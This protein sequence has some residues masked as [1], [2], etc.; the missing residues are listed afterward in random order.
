MWLSS[1][2]TGVLVIYG[3]VRFTRVFFELGELHFLKL[4]PSFN[5]F[6]G[7]SLL[8]L[9]YYLSLVGASCTHGCSFPYY[10]KAECSL[11]V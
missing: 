4:W 10:C 8:I 2:F 9:D 1:K 3:I 11:H 7:I 5:L 6:I